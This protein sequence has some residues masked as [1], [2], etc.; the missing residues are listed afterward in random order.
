MF[1][2]DDI[3]DYFIVFLFL[4]KGSCNVLFY[5]QNSVHKSKTAQQILFCMQ[6]SYKKCST[7]ML[8]C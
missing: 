4:K 2:K 1:Y 5:I 8:T 6:V 3:K 7:T